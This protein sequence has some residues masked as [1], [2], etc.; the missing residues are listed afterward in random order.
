[1]QAASLKV[2]GSRKVAHDVVCVKSAN[3]LFQH[4]RRKESGIFSQTEVNGKRLDP[5]EAWVM[6]LLQ[7]RLQVQ[8]FRFRIMLSLFKTSSQDS[9]KYQMGDTG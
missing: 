6:K 1:M 3:N 2:L 9:R 4:L 7:C 8:Q 5:E